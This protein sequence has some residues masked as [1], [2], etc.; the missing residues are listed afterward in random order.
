LRRF[1]DL[2]GRRP[3]FLCVLLLDVEL[4]TFE[5]LWDFRQAQL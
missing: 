3:T 2:G 5:E 1:I 4:S